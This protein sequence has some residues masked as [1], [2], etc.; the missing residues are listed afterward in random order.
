MKE[1][2]RMNFQN[3]K[4]YLEVTIWSKK[5]GNDQFNRPKINIFSEKKY[6]NLD[7]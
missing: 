6:K 5:A 4:L 2:T 3:L 7:F 1:E